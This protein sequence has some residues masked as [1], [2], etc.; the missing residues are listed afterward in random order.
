MGEAV[1]RC[2]TPA[3]V[4]AMAAA[5]EASWPAELA[6]TAEQIAARIDVFPAGQLVA[7]LDGQVSGAVYAQRLTAEFFAACPKTYDALTDH[8]RFTRTHTDDGEIYHM[9]GVS[10][11]PEARGGG[12]GRLLV[13]RQIKIGQ[14]MPGVRRS[15]GITRPVRYHRHRELLIEDYVHLRDD[16]GAWIDPVLDFHFQAGARLIA[17]YPGYRPED[18]QTLRY[19]VLI[20]YDAPYNH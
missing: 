16:L 6:S 7:D 2:A 12:L 10:V 15:L 4:A 13:D 17:I 14:A 9:I 20:E 11:L 1:L 3:D 19:G 18:Q 5:E 8:G